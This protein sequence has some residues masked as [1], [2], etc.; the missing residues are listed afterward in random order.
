LRLIEQHPPDFTQLDVNLR[1]ETS[2]GIAE[3][4]PRVVHRSHLRPDMASRS[5]FPEQF[6]DVQRL[7]KPC[8]LNS[9]RAL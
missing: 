2:F 4:L 3:R 7:R 8:S 1:E 6:S 9:L 5:P